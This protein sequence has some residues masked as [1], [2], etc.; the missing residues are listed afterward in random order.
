MPHFTTTRRIEFCETDMAGIVH[1][2][3]YYRYMEQAEHELFRSLGLKIAGK[4][5]EGIDVGWPRVAAKCEYRAP[6][7]YDDVITIDLTI[8]KQST[9]S[10]TIEYQFSREGQ[11]LA[12]GEMTTVCCTMQGG[13]MKAIEIP[14]S[15]VAGLASLTS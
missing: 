9:R 1:F 4:T 2:A 10:L 15:Y 6:A 13:T 5:V 11:P 8:V 3:N 12:K 7:R 14:P